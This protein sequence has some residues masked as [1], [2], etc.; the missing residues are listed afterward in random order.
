M[1]QVGYRLVG[2]AT[3]EVIQEWG[4]VWGQMPS[5]PDRVICP[6]GDVVHAPVVGESYGGATLTA[7]MMEAPAP[8]PLPV[9]ESITRRQCAI[10]MR[11]RGM[12]TAR[13]ALDMTRNGTP[14]AIVASLFAQMPGDAGII[15]ETDFAAATYMRNNPLLIQLMQASSASEA[16]IDDFFRS[17]ALR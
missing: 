6:N 11:E 12:I 10:E 2:N 8:A 3:G 17:A 16:D 9:P 13:E 7:W 1:E 14:P 15:A 4:G 5:P